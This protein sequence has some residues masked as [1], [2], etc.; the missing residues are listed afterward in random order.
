MPSET[1]P[2]GRA[3]GVRAVL[4][5]VVLV[6]ALGYF[7]DIY[8]LLLFSMVRTP[9]LRG[10]GVADGDLLGQGAMLLN[11]QMGG[12]LLG[13]ILWGVLGDKRGR[14]SVL[15]GSIALYSLANLANAAVTSIWMYAGLRFIAGI[16]LAGELGA[17]VTLVSEALPAR[18]RGFGTMLV[19]SIGILGAV[20]GYFVA[21]LD[22][23]VAYVTGG[24]L[25]LMLLAAR[26]ALVESPMFTG[27]ARTAAPRGDLRLFVGSLTPRGLAWFRGNGDRLRRL[28][29]A[30]L[31]GI[32]LWC[33]IGIFITFSP[34]LGVDLHVADAPDAAF[35]VMLAYA[36]ASVGSL[37]S[38]T[39]SQVLRSRR[40]ALLAFLGFTTLAT[41]G[42]LLARGASLTWFYALCTALGF[43]AGYWA[44]F[45]QAAAEQFGTNLRATV[46]TAVPN[47]VRGAV[48]PL[49]LSY[50][51]LRPGMGGAAAAVTL[52][53]TS[54]GLAM[55]AVWLMPETYGKELDYV[56]GE[57][58]EL[59]H[60][61]PA[62]T[63]SA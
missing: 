56:E 48:V 19:S 42:F 39:L 55:L 49:T 34:E 8:D 12:L 53:G 6:C 61:S 30:T 22:W 9:S 45:V 2:T 29:L 38:G 62:A 47:L 16:G 11:W 1:T 7:V 5:R 44:V 57:A 4:N 40:V 31:P 63:P 20:G 58:V 14:R 36:G 28:L 60:R 41:G 25:G 50:Q 54:L 59:A 43:G 26:I 17:A 18:L 35:A 27:L 24:V 33:A 21:R 51:A 52:M 15:F 32:P 37:A 46:A 23:R 3:G 13:G 10:L